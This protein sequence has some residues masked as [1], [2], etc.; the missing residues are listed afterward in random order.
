M[1]VRERKKKRTG[2]KE[3]QRLIERLRRKETIVREVKA[4]SDIGR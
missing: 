2:E 1:S 4:S 3:R